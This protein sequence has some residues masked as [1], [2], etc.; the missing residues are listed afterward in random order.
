MLESPALAEFHVMWDGL[1][2]ITGYCIILAQLIGWCTALGVVVMILS[3]PVQIKIMG[4]QG[5]KDAQV[6]LSP[7]PCSRVTR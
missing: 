3:M 1:Y 2:Q 5:K 6:S 4:L 7:Q